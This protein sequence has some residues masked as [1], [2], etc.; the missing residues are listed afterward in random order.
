[1]LTI[2][3]APICY[4]YSDPVL[5]YYIFR[6]LFMNHFHKLT[7]ISSD[8][9]CILGLC[10]LFETILQSKDAQL[11]L[12]LKRID[13]QPLKIVFKWLVRAFSGYLASSQLLDLWDRVLAFNTMEILSGNYS[14]LKHFQL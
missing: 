2:T 4:V 13:A 1:M 9:E 7:I 10:A 12:H 3:V 8:P 6:R 11:F 14:D 5:L